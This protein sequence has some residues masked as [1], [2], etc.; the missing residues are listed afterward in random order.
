ML[1]KNLSK[2]YWTYP[3]SKEQQSELLEMLDKCDW[4]TPSS[5]GS[6]K[7]VVIAYDSETSNYIDPVTGEKK[8]FAFSEMTT[9]L[10]DEKVISVLCRDVNDFVKFITTIAKLAGCK[11]SYEVMTK[12]DGIPIYDESGR[13]R[14]K[15]R[16]NKILRIYVHNL[17]FDDAF[18]ISHMTVYSIFAQSTHK[19]YY[20]V[21]APGVMFLD[22]AVLAQDTLEG[23]GKK[24]KYF[25]VKKA[26][27]DFDYDLLRTP[28]T[29]F[30]EK[31]KGY[32]INDTLVLAAWI[33]EQLKFYNNQI[34]NIPLTMTGIVRRFDRN[35]A[36]AKVE[37]LKELLDDDVIPNW[38]KEEV[39]EYVSYASYEPEKRTPA[40]KVWKEK[41][42]KM[43]AKIKDQ[44]GGNDQYHMNLSQYKE[45]LASYS[46]GFTHS[47]PANTDK[48]LKNVQS[49]DFTSSY[50]TRLLSEKFASSDPMPL[51]D[52]TDEEMLKR[53]S[54]KT[55]ND[56]YFYVFEFSADCIQS[57]VN[58][59]YFYSKSK[60]TYSSCADSNGRVMFA[61]DF[62]TTMN[63]IDWVTFSKVY[64]IQG[65]HFKNILM[66]KQD[67][68]PL[69]IILDTLHFY[70]Q[71]TELKNVE[72]REDDYMRGKARLNAGSYGL[73]V[74]SPLK[75]PI[76]Y[77]KENGWKTIKRDPIAEVKAWKEYDANPNRFVYYPVGTQI[78]SYSKQKLWEGILECKDDFI[79]ADT[80]SLK[81]LNANKH[82]PFIDSFNKRITEKIRKTLK[83]Y[84]LDEY[85]MHPVDIKGKEHQLGVWDPNDGFYSYFKTLGA[86]R[87]IDIDK[88]TGAFQITVAGLSKKAGAK[89]MLDKTQTQYSTDEFGNFIM[90]APSRNYH[91]VFNFFTDQMAIPAKYTGKLAHFYIDEYDS[92]KVKDY[93]G[94]TYQVPAGSGCL[95]KA[96]D[97]HMSIADEFLQVIKLAGEGFE[98][99]PNDR[100]NALN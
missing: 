19:P 65:G 4:E 45:V 30:S 62:K 26:V 11:L 94:N 18:I 44:L 68:L 76:C 43:Q 9:F 1:N 59:D 64:D 38:M 25:L 6:T 42:E 97:F 92:F 91:R 77:T 87:Y 60:C 57:K 20:V 69:F 48:V 61:Y 51:K 98:E 28:L 56:D 81:V 63:S 36:D 37:E 75:D 58:F 3:L 50:P 29:V 88:E 93:Q 82:K 7:H 71:K 74:Q 72:G 21:Y 86:K 47:N 14:F 34:S 96:V 10:S 54:S 39:K 15:E 35:T 78:S 100:L 27:G 70:K 49:W 41:V 52:V 40:H 24:L 5:K 67:Y 90:K 22:S 80:D 33:K 8:P 53:L 89:Y 83:H 84:G 2:V 12:D 66:F 95:L 55:L 17:P 79:Y 23:L 46:G 16:K 73:F 13:P 31:E 32:V 99:D 85:L